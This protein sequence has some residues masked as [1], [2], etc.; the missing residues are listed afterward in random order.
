MMLHGRH[1]GHRDRP[2]AVVAVDDRDVPVL[3]PGGVA[4]LEEVAV[5]REG[6]L[7]RDREEQ[8][9][10]AGFHQPLGQEVCSRQAAASVR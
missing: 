4:L 2:A 3:R 6:G 8:V 5:R 10:A 9:V 1:D 7:V